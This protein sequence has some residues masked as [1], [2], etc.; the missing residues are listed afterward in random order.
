MGAGTAA[1]GMPAATRGGHPRRALSVR[2]AG[3]AAEAG[4]RSLVTAI[5]GGVGAGAGI[6]R[7]AGDRGV[8]TGTA[9]AVAGVGVATRSLIATEVAARTAAR[10]AAAD[11]RVRAGVG[12]GAR[13]TSAINGTRKTR[14]TRK[15]R[16][17]RKTRETRASAR[18]AVR[19]VSRPLRMH[20]R[21]HPPL[22]LLPLQLPL[23]PR[24]THLQNRGG[25]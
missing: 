6:A 16:R 13:A 18:A 22:P 9:G 20:P 10:G 4:A 2:E 11:L 12:A 5:P 17:T 14:K 23:S 7:T 24:V 8:V 15:T 21:G 3:A 1:L 25:L 19:I